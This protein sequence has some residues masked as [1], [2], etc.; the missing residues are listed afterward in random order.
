MV[1]RLDYPPVVSISR[2][3][4]PSF[5]RPVEVWFGGVKLVDGYVRLAGYHD[6]FQDDTGVDLS[7]WEGILD[8]PSSFDVRVLVNEELDLRFLDDWAGKAVLIDTSGR[9]RGTGDIPFD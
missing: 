5:N 3:R 4:R 7:S 9:I 2:K 8:I 1:S 6:G